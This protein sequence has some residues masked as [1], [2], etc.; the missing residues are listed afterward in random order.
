MHCKS[1]MG[2]YC[3]KL[4]IFF[5]LLHYARNGSVLLG[6]VEPYRL[7]SYQI[8]M[9][10]ES[11]KP[12]YMFIEEEKGVFIAIYFY[13]IYI[14][15]FFFY[16]S[17]NQSILLVFCGKFSFIHWFHQYYYLKIARVSSA[18]FAT[19]GKLAHTINTHMNN[20]NYVLCI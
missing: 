17:W 11:T 4:L 2:I 16:L 12:I 10:Y 9:I 20:C 3:Y 7:I 13:F 5:I 15:L 19:V 18:V 6:L 1:K 8:R 14:S